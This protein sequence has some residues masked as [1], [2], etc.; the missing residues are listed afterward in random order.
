M[1]S[2]E[3]LTNILLLVYQCRLVVILSKPELK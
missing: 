3:A 2:S 1:V